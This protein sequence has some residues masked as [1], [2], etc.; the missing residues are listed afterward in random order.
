MRTM[1]VLT[2]KDALVPPAGMNTLEGTPATPLL[3]ERMTVAPPAGAPRVRVTVPT[4]DCRPPTTL[5]GFSVSE[6]TV[7]GGRG[8]GV[9]VSD[10]DLVAPP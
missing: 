1:D 2:V 3:L 5:E 4:E 6:E 10:A 9:T 8:T 7:G